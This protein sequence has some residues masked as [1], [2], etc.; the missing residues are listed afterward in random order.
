MSFI[1]CYLISHIVCVRMYLKGQI[2]E[3]DNGRLVHLQLVMCYYLRNWL[4]VI[5]EVKLVALSQLGI[6][7]FLFC[8]IT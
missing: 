6:N 5:L 8:K 4:N 1:V 2:V 3:E 7:A